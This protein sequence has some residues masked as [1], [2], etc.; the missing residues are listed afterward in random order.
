VVSACG[1]GFT[2]VVAIAVNNTGRTWIA[3]NTT[4]CLQTTKDA[5]EKQSLEPNRLHGFVVA[6]DTASGTSTS[7][8]YA[9]YV[10]RVPNQ[11][12][13]LRVDDEGNAYVAGTT[14]STDFPHERTYSVG[15]KST[16]SGGFI[17]VLNPAGSAMQWSALLPGAH[18]NALAIDGS[19]TVYVTGGAKSRSSGG[20]HD[21]VLVAA[22]SD[23]GNRLSYA[24][25]FG[26]PP[27]AEGRAIS[28]DPKGNWV[29][30]SGAANAAGSPVSFA[31]GLQPC[32]TGVMRSDFALRQA[33]ADGPEIAIGPALDAFADSS[34]RSA[35]AAGFRETRKKMS[36]SVQSA[37]PCASV[38]AP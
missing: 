28:T 12:T 27:A 16:P 7:P 2:S 3:G 5:F 22:L 4:A 32:K 35:F 18:L 21:D 19:G 13:G 6:I 29:F 30:V 36:V 33:V 14:T 11:V 17:A 37:A 1:D 23:K 25:H 34:G 31:M 24:A 26:A 15:E 8:V 20:P 10:S 38:K 9:T